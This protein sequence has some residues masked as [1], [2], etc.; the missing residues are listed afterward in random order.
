MS[1]ELVDQG[2][3]E[4]DVIVTHGPFVMTKTGAFVVKPASFDEWYAVFS[5]C[6]QASGAIQFWI[7]DL[8][9]YGEKSYGEKYTQAL[10][11]TGYAEQT[12]M[13][14]SWVARSIHK[15][16]R[17]ENLS[18]AHHAEVAPLKPEDQR[19]WLD[20][21]ETEGMTRQQLRESIKQ[22]RHAVEQQPVTLWVVVSCSSAED[23]TKLYNRMLMEGRN[24]RMSTRE[25]FGPETKSIAESEAVGK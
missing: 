11:M 5:W 18:F 15:S 19:R 12:L 21:A 1:Y 3:T 24:V 4:D 7:G 22:E 2:V 25:P 10:E 17:K 13:N 14:A 16:D 6:Q 23:Q 9:E 20:K 8:L